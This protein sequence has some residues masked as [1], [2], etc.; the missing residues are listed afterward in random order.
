MKVKHKIRND[1]NPTLKQALIGKNKSFWHEAIK[2]EL[3]QLMDKNVYEFTSFDNLPEGS[4]VYPI[5]MILKRKRDPK[6]GEIQKYKAR[7]V[8]LGNRLKESEE[9]K[10]VFSPTS[11]SHS[12]G[13]LFSIAAK[14]NLI[15]AGF[16]VSGAFLYPDL[17]TTDIIYMSIP[18]EIEFE[19]HGKKG[20]WKLNLRFTASSK[21]VFRAYLNTFDIKKIS[22][23][24]IR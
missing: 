4:K 10:D 24:K 6:T 16:D 15:M 13:L 9:M 18:K 12:L 1:D 21:S 22:S 17:N 8:F 14:R 7:L 11:N 5:M 3:Q 20:V 2:K 19:N 23:I